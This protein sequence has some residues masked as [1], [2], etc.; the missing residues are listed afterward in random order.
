M[1]FASSDKFQIELAAFFARNNQDVIEGRVLKEDLGIIKSKWNILSKEEQKAY[2]KKYACYPPQASN[3]ITD[4]L[5][6]K[7]MQPWNGNQSLDLT[8]EQQQKIIKEILSFKNDG[9]P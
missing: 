2:A 7:H 3:S 4:R 9:Q 5:W 8:P 1:A 6:K